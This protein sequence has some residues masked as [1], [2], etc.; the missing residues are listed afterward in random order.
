MSPTNVQNTIEEVLNDVDSPGMAKLLSL[1]G[2][3]RIAEASDLV[4]EALRR[5]TNERVLIAA[6]D[7]C[8]SITKKSARGEVS[9]RL[10]DLADQFL[11]KRFMFVP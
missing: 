4:S 11:D 6:I 5:S 7:A 10:L 8:R 1:C 3:F 9:D 2:R